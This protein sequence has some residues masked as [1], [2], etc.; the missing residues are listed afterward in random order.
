MRIQSTITDLTEVQWKHLH[1]AIK[2]EYDLKEGSTRVCATFIR[3]E[4]ERH[5]EL[6]LSIYVALLQG[7]N[8]SKSMSA[9]TEKLWGP[10]GPEAFAQ[11][12]A[13]RRSRPVLPTPGQV[14]DLSAA[15][16]AALASEMNE[17]DADL[18]DSIS[19]YPSREHY[20]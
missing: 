4:E 10:G 17:E 7:L 6:P 19:E 12:A 13:D 8:L 2:T 9:S 5:V 11:R 15:D 20:E 1:Q 3:D 16:A 18:L 14:R